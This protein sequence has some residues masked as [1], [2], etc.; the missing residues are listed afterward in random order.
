M[1]TQRL[2]GGRY[3]FLTLFGQRKIHT[4]EMT[5]IEAGLV[6]L[7]PIISKDHQRIAIGHCIGKGFLIREQLGGLHIIKQ[8]AEQDIRGLRRCGGL[9]LGVGAE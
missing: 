3:V 5:K 6:F 2:P 1:L 4:D 8:R 7:H 9:F